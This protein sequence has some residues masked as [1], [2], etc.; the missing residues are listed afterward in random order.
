MC[1]NPP[2]SLEK[3][4]SDAPKKIVNYKEHGRLKPDFEH[5]GFLERRRRRRRRRRKKKNPNFSQMDIKAVEDEDRQ[6]THRRKQENNQDDGG[7]FATIFGGRPYK[8]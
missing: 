6:A 2:S 3:E 4:G 1:T 8:S 5:Q 7:A